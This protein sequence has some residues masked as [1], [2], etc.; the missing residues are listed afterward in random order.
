MK[1]FLDIREYSNHSKLQKHLYKVKY[2]YQKISLTK[3][4]TKC[5]KIQYE[6]GAQIFLNDQ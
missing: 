3:I 6:S 2:I 5:V 4:S 1:V